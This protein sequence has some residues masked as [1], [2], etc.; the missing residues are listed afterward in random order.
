MHPERFSP[1]EITAIR[2]SQGHRFEAQYQQD[3]VEREGGFFTPEELEWY[4]TSEMPAHTSLRWMIGADY[5]TSAKTT[6]D[7]SAI[8]AA[9]M[10]HKG[11]IWV[12][13]DSILKRLDPLEAVRS[14]I[15]LAKRLDTRV[16]GHEKGVIANTLKP[17]FTQEQTRQG[18]YVSTENYARTAGKAVHAAA[19]KGLMQS[20]RV[21]LPRVLRAVWE[22][23]L[24]RFR[25][26]VDGDQDDLI[27]ALATIGILIERAVIKP[28]RPGTNERVTTDVEDDDAVWTKLMAGSITKPP[29]TLRRLN[30]DP[31]P[32]RKPIA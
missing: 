19:I 3:P 32:T 30:G 11:T 29:S 2:I 8:I 27:D 4:D 14:T 6:S 21:K 26:D 10:D 15:A 1:E 7:H 18:H 16:L 20:H 5:A 13:P 28:P 25:P 12:H 24:L 9:G 31:Y 22:P 23:L 17:L